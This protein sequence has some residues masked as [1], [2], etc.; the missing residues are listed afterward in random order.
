VDKD[1]CADVVSFTRGRSLSRGG[2]PL[3]YVNISY[4]KKMEADDT[5]AQASSIFEP[6]HSMALATLYGATSPAPVSDYLHRLV[7]ILMAMGMTI[8]SR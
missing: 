3:G 1:G 2:N 8:L 5:A 7:A 6:Q 4:G